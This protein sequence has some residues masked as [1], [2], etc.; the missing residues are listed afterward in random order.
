MKLLVLALV[1]VA[2]VFGAKCMTIRKDLVSERQ[3]IDADWAQVDAAL[4]HRASIVPE[5]TNLV[6]SEAPD[7]GSTILNSS[8]L[9][10]SYA[11]FCLKKK[12]TSTYLSCHR[13]NSS[14]IYSICHT[15]QYI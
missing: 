7:E 12:K 13:N 11:V 2:L 6:Q 5:L 8:H 4:E 15:L 1:A 3:A 14:I 10:I 9:V